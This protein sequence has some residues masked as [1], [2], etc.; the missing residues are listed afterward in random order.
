MNEFNRM[1]TCSGFE[2]P[3][4]QEK[5]ERVVIVSQAR[6]LQCNLMVELFKFEQFKSVTDVDHHAFNKQNSNNYKN[7]THAPME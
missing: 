7:R 5:Y 2:K 4:G 3:F 6:K 1:F